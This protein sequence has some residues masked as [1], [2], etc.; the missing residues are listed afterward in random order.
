MALTFTPTAGSLTLTVTGS[1]LNAQFEAGAF[2][3]SW[4]PT[5]GA[6]VTRAADSATMPTAAWLTSTAAWS[7][8]VD[9]ML[10]VASG[11]S[12]Y[13]QIDDG[14][15]ANRSL[16]TTDV[17][18][19]VMRF[20]ESNTSVTTI[21]SIGAGGLTGG[22]P[23]K[24]A[25]SSVSGAHGIALNGAVPAAMQ[26]LRTPAVTTLRLGRSVAAAVGSLYVRR[27]RYWP[28]ALSAAELQQVTT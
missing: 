27:F 3:T 9:A 1:V 2:V 13:A 15:N 22:N 14:T 23:F 8:A 18:T 17:D 12:T 11:A 25:I 16:M 7:V 28:R 26:A 5:A 4:I 20:L 10:P 24:A 6:T 21:N 19:L